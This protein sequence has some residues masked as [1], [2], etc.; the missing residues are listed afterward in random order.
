[1]LADTQSPSQ[2]TVKTPDKPSDLSHDTSSEKVTVYV[3]GAVEK[4]G[5]YELSQGDRL[6]DAIEMAGGFSDDADKEYLNLAAFVEDGLKVRVPTVEEAAQAKD[7][8]QDLSSQSITGGQNQDKSSGKVNINTADAAQLVT[9]PGIGESRAADII[10]YRTEHGNFKSV[11]EI[12]NVT[13]IKQK[14]FDR[15]K[16][17]ITV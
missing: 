16:N 1:M 6:A 4:S 9:I 13:G 8:V 2:G 15:I 3:C 7:E 12:M 14:M 17:C 11:E 5:V 10:A